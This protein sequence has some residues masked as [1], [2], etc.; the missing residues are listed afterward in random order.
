MEAGHWRWMGSKYFARGHTVQVHR[1]LC[2][3]R[4][5]SS[6]RDHLWR[7]IR[8]FISECLAGPWEFGFK[9][10]VIFI[11]SA[12]LFLVLWSFW[13]VWNLNCLHF[14]VVLA[15]DIIW[16]CNAKTRSTT[17]F[18]LSPSFVITEIVF[19]HQLGKHFR[20]CLGMEGTGTGCPLYS[21][22]CCNETVGILLRTLSPWIWTGGP[23]KNVWCVSF[24]HYGVY[25]L[26]KIVW[27][28]GPLW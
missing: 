22:C 5:W 17:L 26:L 10:P 20:P 4:G 23:T 1:W 2:C 19:N 28:F 25:L 6:S 24:L 14:W 8:I 9:D 3:L 13:R 12:F 11:I 16:W 18:I 27:L 15:F 21:V 7:F